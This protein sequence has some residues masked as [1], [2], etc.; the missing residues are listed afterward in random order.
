MVRLD[1]GRIKD[2]GCK[3]LETATGVGNAIAFPM[4][5]LSGAF[6]PIEIMP[7]YLQFVAKLLPL[8]YFHQGLRNI[9]I[10]NNL[11]QAFT[12]FLVLGVLAILFIPL[13]IKVTKWKEL[14]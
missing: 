6:W 5:F 2:G 14:D 10:L 4:M 7:D 3:M 9:M 8:Y 12:S 1:F 13:A 11:D